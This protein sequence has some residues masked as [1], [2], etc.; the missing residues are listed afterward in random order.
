MCLDRITGALIWGLDPIEKWK[1][2]VPQWYTGQCPLVD[3]GVLV[4][5]VGGEALMAGID[6]ASGSV[7]WTSPN[8][9][10]A[11]SSHA[12]VMPMELDGRPLYLASMSTGLY[13]ISAEASLRGTILFRIPDWTVQVEVPSPLALPGGRV[14]L[15]AGY[16]A[17][18]ML[19]RLGWKGAPGAGIEYTIEFRNAPGVGL[20]CEQQTPIL[21]GDKIYGIETRD[22]GEL[23]DL[24]VCMNLDGSFA[25]TSGA[26]RRFGLGPYLEGD[27]KFYILSDT[28]T[29]TI[30][31]SGGDSYRE[32]SRNRVFEAT[33][34]WAPMALVGT[35]LLARDEK[36]LLC[37]DLEAR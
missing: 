21:Y 4:L 20:S 3:D 24:F 18:N 6:L 22:S 13:G 9:D 23:H 8:P 5:S 16:G 33:D 19:V 37:L 2:E 32:I 25:W 35:R 31:A 26:G 17:G 30:A 15:T 34:A 36:Q 7:L 12:S 29:L 1:A 11:K 10:G 14:F 27:G 28:G